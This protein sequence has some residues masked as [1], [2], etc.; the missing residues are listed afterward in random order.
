MKK[1][2]KQLLSF[3]GYTITKLDSNF[4][5]SS[6]YIIGNLFNKNLRLIIFDIGA[7]IGQSAEKYGSLYKSN[8]LFF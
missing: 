4:A 2:I 5:T 8:Y 6:D 1:L 7:N 3:F